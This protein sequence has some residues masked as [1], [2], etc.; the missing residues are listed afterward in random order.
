MDEKNKHTNEHHEHHKHHHHHHHR[1]R[2][3]WWWFWGIIGVIFVAAILTGGFMYKNLRDATNNAYSPVSKTNQSN[4]NR[5]KL[6]K[7]LDE[8]KPINILLLG[9]DT[10]AMGRDYKGRTDT[11]MMLTINPQKEETRVTSIPRDMKAKLP[12]YPE[13]GFTKINSAYA[14]GGVQETIKTLD[15]YYS[16]PIDGYLLVNMGGLVKGIDQVG[17]V[18]AVS[19]LTF[20]NMGYKFV[21]GH[22]Y[23]LNGKKALAFSQTRHGDPNNDYGR[24]DRERRVIVA[25]LKKS[26]S[27]STLLNTKFLDSMSSNMQTDLTMNQMMKIAMDYRKATDKTYTDHAQGQGQMI[28]TPKFGQMEEEFINQKERQRVSNKIRQTLDINKTTVVEDGE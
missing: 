25:L 12:G 22:E 5:A 1:W 6:D 16:V 24:Q 2:K 8:K 19:P 20:E 11:I 4:K 9:T 26:V 21:K 10:G 28:D 13:D 15:K 17:G 27:P 14:V 7:L 18:D 23:H 3:F